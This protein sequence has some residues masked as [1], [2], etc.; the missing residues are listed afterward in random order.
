MVLQGEAVVN[1]LAAPPPGALPE[2]FRGVSLAPYSK[3]GREL[4]CPAGQ[5][6]MIPAGWW[7][8]IG[9]EARLLA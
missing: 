5:T 9:S 7:Y 2:G 1:L 3:G 8:S 4:R 6:M